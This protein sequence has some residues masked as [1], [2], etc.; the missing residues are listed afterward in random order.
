[1]VKY[2]ILRCNLVLSSVLDL[3]FVMAPF[4]QIFLP[5]LC[6]LYH[7]YAYNSSKNY[8]YERYIPV[9]LATRLRAERPGFDTRQGQEIPLFFIA[10]RPALGPIHPVVM[11]D[12]FRG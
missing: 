9:G 7:I 5:K 2:K 3:G 11:R 8:I 10:F 1:M 12:Y 4:I 6:N